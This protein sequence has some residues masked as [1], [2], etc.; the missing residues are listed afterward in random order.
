[1][2]TG[3]PLVILIAALLEGLA[4]GCIRYIGSGG[5]DN[6]SSNVLLALANAN[7]LVR[8]LACLDNV[9]DVATELAAGF[10]LLSGSLHHCLLFDDFL[11]FYEQL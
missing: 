9:A 3:L 10:L 6:P 1:L 2:E 7:I 11:A 8:F 4:I 5:K